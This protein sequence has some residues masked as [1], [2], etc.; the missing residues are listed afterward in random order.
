LIDGAARVGLRP[1]NLDAAAIEVACIGSAAFVHVRFG[2]EDQHL[3]R[4]VDEHVTAF[5]VD[6][7]GCPEVLV[8][9]F[10][11]EGPPGCVAEMPRRARALPPRT[12]SSGHGP[13]L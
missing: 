5:D 4:G 7:D 9:R 6:H 8:G 12:A 2:H 10:A 11:A 1:L 3:T 13:P